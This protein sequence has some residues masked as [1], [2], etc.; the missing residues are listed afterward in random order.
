MKLYFAGGLQ[1]SH[2]QK[3]EKLQ[4]PVKILGSYWEA[5][6]NAGNIKAF[7][8]HKYATNLFID[9]GA[10]SAFTKQASIDLDQ[11]AEFLKAY[12]NRKS[13]YASLDVIGD[14]KATRRNQEKLEAK[15]LEPI[16][17]FHFN[18]PE[19][20][21][22]RLVS[23]Y[24]YIALGGLVPISMQRKTMQQW[25]DYCFSI[26]KTNTKVHGFGVNS[27]WAWER[28]PFYS[29]DATSWLMGEKFRRTI[30][31]ENGKVKTS[32]KNDGIKSI[33][34][35]KAHTDKY[36]EQSLANAEAYLQLEQRVTKLW[37]SRGVKWD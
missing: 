23:K 24:N 4:K 13:V 12:A 31:L 25:L 22:K 19:T 27:L 10:F 36:Y 32:H 16:P 5:N 15:G 33:K 6:N 1:K 18:S 28:Y 17:T 9:S 7:F 30:Y 2:S 20:E 29:V 8:Q 34:S 21:L 14:W 11:Y 37:E 3:L 26:I 35:M